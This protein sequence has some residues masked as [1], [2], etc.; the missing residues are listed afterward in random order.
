MAEEAVDRMLTMDAANEAVAE[1]AAVAAAAEKAA[2]EKAA[3]EKAAACALRACSMSQLHRQG[4]QGC[5]DPLGGLAR[6]P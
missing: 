5:F 1:A 6:P 2:A 3:A 4:G